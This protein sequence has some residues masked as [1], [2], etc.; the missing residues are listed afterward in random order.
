MQI[1]LCACS[2]QMHLWLCGHFVVIA[3][4]FVATRNKI[5]VAIFCNELGWLD[6]PRLQEIHQKQISK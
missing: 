6:A 3:K 1:L 4:K 5:V 2:F